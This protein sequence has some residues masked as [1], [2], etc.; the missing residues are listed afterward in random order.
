MSSSLDDKRPANGRPRR[1]VL[2]EGNVRTRLTAVETEA[3][4]E[5][6]AKVREEFYEI[7]EARD[8]LRKAIGT[9][10]EHPRG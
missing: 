7:V 3:V 5:T 9:P 4:L 10:G 8:E 6:L 1:I 2:V